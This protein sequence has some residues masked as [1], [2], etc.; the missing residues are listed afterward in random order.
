MNGKLGVNVIVDFEGASVT[1]VVRGSVNARN[2]P[3]LHSLTHRA[4]SLGDGLTI[5]L[6]LMAA[7][8]ETVVLDALQS[9]AS[10]RLLPLVHRPRTGV[11]HCRSGY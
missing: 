8:V 6:E 1:I 10:M 2:V 3:A 5:T 11:G 9:Y 4:N 7:T